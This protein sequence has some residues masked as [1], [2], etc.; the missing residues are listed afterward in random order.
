M[1]QRSTISRECVNEI[2]IRLDI[3][4]LILFKLYRFYLAQN[5][6]QIICSIICFI[7]VDADSY[8][9]LVKLLI[10]HF[11]LLSNTRQ[12]ISVSF[13]RM[14]MNFVLSFQALTDT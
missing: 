13:S 7:R 8:N 14:M 2:N 10:N 12:N 9:P 3:L 5:F 4:S 6:I 11:E 1:S